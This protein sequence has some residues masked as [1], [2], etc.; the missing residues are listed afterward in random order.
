[1]NHFS[2]NRIPTLK[3][4]APSMCIRVGILIVPKPVRDDGENGPVDRR[5]IMRV[6][7]F[8]RMAMQPI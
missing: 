6:Y 3:A 8:R 2:R 7:N 4:L 1:M 5:V